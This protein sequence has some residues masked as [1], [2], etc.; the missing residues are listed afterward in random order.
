MK[1]YDV[2]CTALNRY[3]LQV[4]ASRNCNDET[5]LE[6]MLKWAEKQPEC[7]RVVLEIVSI[8]GEQP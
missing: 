3:G 2:V 4:I 6:E 7:V 1:Q 8:S 5:S